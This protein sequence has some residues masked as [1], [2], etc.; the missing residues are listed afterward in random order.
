MAP[1]ITK[2]QT[3]HSFKDAT[4]KCPKTPGYC[5]TRAK[6]D[7]LLT[8]LHVFGLLAT[9]IV[10][11][12]VSTAE[13]YASVSTMSFMFPLRLTGLCTWQF[14][15]LSLTSSCLAS[16]LLHWFYCSG[17]VDWCES[18]VEHE[19]QSLHTSRPVL[20]YAKLLLIRYRWAL[21]AF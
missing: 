4:I 16:K 10:C 12:P 2:Q 20:R 14:D 15:Y 7:W 6:S 11:N 1:A 13:P 5:E 19:L 3:K 9:I 17:Q 18:V 21:A 8:L